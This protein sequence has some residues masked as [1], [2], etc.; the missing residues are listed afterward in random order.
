[1]LTVRLLGQPAI[2]RDGA[3]H[4]G[5]RGHKA[6]GLLAYLLLAET[7]PSRDWLV[8]L[9]FPDADDPLAALRWNLAELRRRL[10]DRGLFGG[11][12]IRRDLPPGIV[13][14]V[15]LLRS[16]S[17]V[18]GSRLPGLGRELL[19]GIDF[20]RTPAFDAWLLNERRYA[21][22]LGG[23]ILREAA[24]AR[25]GLGQPVEA[26][27]VATRLVEL[28]PLDEENQALLVRAYAAAGD[29]AGAARQLEAAVDLLRRELGVEPGPSLRSAG[30]A[31][32]GSPTA[33]VAVGRAAALAQLEAGETA[34]RAG[35]LEAGL[36]CLRR[37]I[38]EADACGDLKLKS[39]A[40]FVFGST[41]VHAGRNRV[42]EGATALHEMLSIAEQVGTA[43][44]LAAAHRELAWPEFLAARYARAEAWLGRAAELADGDPAERA[45][46]STVLGMVLTEVGRYGAAGEAL[47][48]AVDAAASVGEARRLGLAQ[49]MLGRFHLLRGELD[50]ARP[51]LEHALQIARAE[52][53]TSFIAF[54]EAF[55]GELELLD[56]HLE[57]AA[58]LLEHGFATASQV[59]DVCYESLTGRGLGL[60]AECRGDIDDAVARL[61]DARM[62]LV[63]TPDHTWSQ[64]YA[65]EA[66]VAVGARHRL[67]ETRTWARDLESLAGRTG[68][69]ELLVRAH[70]GRAQLG[71]RDALEAA[72]VL[73]RDIDNPS[74]DARLVEVG[75]S[76]PRVGTPGSQRGLSR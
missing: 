43:G 61:T 29:Q 50:R 38:A 67:A 39:R 62:R 55:L 66:M 15:H 49:A 9:L 14:D 70:L 41:L 75:E 8:G 27:A 69:R 72:S 74:L 7:P 19:E 47:R 54:P 34:V 46:I 31:T 48:D 28:D 40:L 35:A 25:L 22:T 71:D 12:P 33:P 3:S 58:E 1:M 36:E 24:L 6:W 45:S 5:P 63:R 32:P 23:A 16:G 65:L 52:G 11:D 4:A 59:G 13:V 26:I 60:L 17:W 64:A 2:E 53:W 30:R 76:S 73:A 68:M 44:T 57:R 42:D 18:E 20:S 51:P 21:A 37:A 10:G 56:G